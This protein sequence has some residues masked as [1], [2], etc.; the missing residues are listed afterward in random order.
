MTCVLKFNFTQKYTHAEFRIQIFLFSPF[1][2][3]Q[4]LQ[5]LTEEFGTEIENI[6]GNI[7]NYFVAHSVIEYIANFVNIYLCMKQISPK[8]WLKSNLLIYPISNFVV[9]N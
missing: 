5:A 7:F 2:I 8:T 4:H 6:I 1:P 3:V 9:K